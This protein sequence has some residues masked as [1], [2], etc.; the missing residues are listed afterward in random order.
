MSTKLPQIHH[1]AMRQRYAAGWTLRELVAE[2]GFSDSYIYRAVR[3]V[4]RTTTPKQRKELLQI[5]TPKMTLDEML[6]EEPHL[7]LYRFAAGTLADHFIEA[8]YRKRD[9]ERDLGEVCKGMSLKEIVETQPRLL[10][11]VMVRIE[12]LHPVKREG[13]QN[14]GR[15]PKYETR[16]D[17]VEE[18][19]RNDP[20]KF[21]PDSEVMRDIARWAIARAL[22]KK[23]F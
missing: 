17:P 22:D 12:T 9:V 6:M 16:I 10:L 5:H 19:F 4:R 14:V 1:T 13:G 21:N 11:R 2:Y 8:L 3:S 7:L 15:G 23:P 18:L 20:D